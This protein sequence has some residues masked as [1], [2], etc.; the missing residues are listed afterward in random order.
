M[1]DLSRSYFRCT[2]LIYHQNRL[3]EMVLIRGLNICFFLRSKKKISLNYPQYP[4]LPGVD[5]GGGYPC[6]N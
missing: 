4:I 1:L 3:V 6:Q 5:G 2:L